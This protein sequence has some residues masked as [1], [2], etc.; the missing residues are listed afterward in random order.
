[1]ANRVIRTLGILTSGGDS[2]GMNAA[3]RAVVKAAHR[4]NIRVFG[5]YNGYQGIL[6]EDFIELNSRIISGILEQGGTILQSSRCKAFYEEEGRKR[7]VRILQENHFDAL[8]VIG[9]DG[10]LTGANELHKLGVRVI[11]L[12]GTIDND[13]AGTDVGIGFDTAANT[14]VEMVDKIKDTARSHRRCFL[15]EVMGRGSGHLALMTAISTGAEVAVIPEFVPNFDRIRM[16]LGYRYRDSVDNSIIVLAEGVSSAEE[17]ERQLLGTDLAT[18]LVEQE[19]RKTV[20]GH[21]QRGGSP[22]FRDRLIAGRMG[23]FAV[24]GLVSGESGMMVALQKSRLTLV[25]FEMVIGRP[26]PIGT[27][28]IRLAR[29]L[30]IE[31]GDPPEAL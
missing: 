24:L 30:G 13:I 6:D 11:G 21:V 3:I 22:S 5:F 9:G 25:P 14:I 31:I 18:P 2:P 4:E 23:E 29:H 16:M 28:V 7:A 10:S 8:V 27:D 12:P 19:V 15:V 26:N 1:M 20:L 17:F